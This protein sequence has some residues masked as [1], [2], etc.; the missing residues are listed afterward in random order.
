MKSLF[1]KAPLAIVV[2]ALTLTGCQMTDKQQTQAEAAATG[3]AVGAI[4]GG[5]VTDS[6]EG[7]LVGATIGATIGMMYAEHVADKKEEYADNEKY[8]E[9]V[10]AEADKLIDISSKKREELTGKLADNNKKLAAIKEGRTEQVEDNAELNAQINAYNN[11]LKNT[12]YL[13]IVL[14]REIE[15]QKKVLDKERDVIPV[16]YVTQSE[17]KIA[18]LQD[19]IKGLQNLKTSLA[20]LEHKRLY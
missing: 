1:N 9:A 11:E 2:A 3:A 16:A 15:V 6:K 14:E 18:T 19:E 10:L 20:S 8:M 12:E 5:L 17:S 13:L 4:V 7:A